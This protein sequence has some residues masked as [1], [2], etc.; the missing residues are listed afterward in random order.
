MVRDSR[1]LAGGR[2]ERDRHSYPPGTGAADRH[3]HRHLVNGLRSGRPESRVARSQCR[4]RIV[5]AKPEHAEPV[6]LC[7][8]GEASLG[9]LDE[10]DA[11]L[12]DLLIMSNLPDGF[13][14]LDHIEPDSGIAMDVPTL[15]QLPGL[16]T[17]FSTWFYT[18]IR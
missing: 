6:G 13:K 1:Q 14:T 3:R 18:P 16:N 2:Q 11:L 17:A 5:L 9:T 10:I 7:L 12:K 8:G 15:P 4:G